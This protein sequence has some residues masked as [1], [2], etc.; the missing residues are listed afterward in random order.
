[1]TDIKHWAFSLCIVL[2]VTGIFMRLLPERSN[3]KTVRFVVTLII[4]VCIFKL[5]VSRLGD[6]LSADIPDDNA[7]AVSEYEN[8]L[9]N[10]I[11]DSVGSAL[12][13]KISGIVRQYDQNSSV[14]LDF[15]S[16]KIIVNISGT[17]FDSYTRIRLEA[18]IKAAYD[19]KLE[20]IYKE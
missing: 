16:D 7:E 19:G 4:L 8:D 13:E 17:R 12:E 15:T 10:R 2:I 11:S 5:D 9:K 18:Q 14:K 1:M 20:F 6:R 3:K